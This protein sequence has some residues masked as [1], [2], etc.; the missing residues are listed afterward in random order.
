MRRSRSRR[1]VPSGS[2]RAARAH[3]FVIVE[4]DDARVRR[5]A[6]GREQRAH[7][8]VTAR[9]VVEARRVQQLFVHAAEGRARRVVQAE[10][11]AEHVLHSARRG[12]ARGAP[13]G[14][15]PCRG[16]A[17]A[18]GASARSAPGRRCSRRGSGGWRGSARGRSAARGPRGAPPCA[19]VLAHEH[20]ARD[21]QIAIEPRGV[22]DSPVD[23]DA[24]LPVTVARRLR[25]RFH[26]QVRRIGVRA[27]H[28]KSRGR[29]GLA[30]HHEREQRAA[31]H[32]MSACPPARAPTPRARRERR[33]PRP[34]GAA[35]LPRS[36][37]RASGCDPRRP[38]DPAHLPGLFVEGRRA[39]R[40]S[41]GSVRRGSC[42]GPSSPPS[43]P[44]GADE[45]QDQPRGVRAEAA[46]ARYFVC[47]SITV[48]GM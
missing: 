34:R 24:H 19:A 47:W 32:D 4:R 14:P 11:V 10:I 6:R 7:G 33:T 21:R 31:A 23:L 39:R 42:P 3:L 12:P 20:A 48:T 37:G 29:G 5:G 22:E 2:R 27:E 38:P 8:G 17:W 26:A 41:S 25:R 43:L 40:R 28:A 30:A 15:P 18:R 36:R 16:P 45:R 44:G 13:R 9:Q 35:R 46:F 1:A